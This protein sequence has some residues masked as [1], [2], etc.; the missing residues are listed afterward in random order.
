MYKSTDNCS[1]TLDHST[2]SSNPLPFFPNMGT[3]I[4]MIHCDSTLCAHL[5]G[6]KA[7]VEARN[8]AMKDRLEHL[9]AM[10]AINI[11]MQDRVAL[12]GDDNDDDPFMEDEPE[13]A[14]TVKT[15]ANSHEGT[16]SVKKE[17]EQ[18]ISDVKT[19]DGHSQSPG[20]SPRLGNGHPQ[21]ASS[22]INGS[23]PLSS[24]PPSG[25]SP[26]AFHRHW[27]DN[28]VS[29]L[30]CGGIIVVSLMLS[31]LFCIRVGESNDDG[32]QSGAA[33]DG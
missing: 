16:S 7:N 31:P 19:E 11:Q 14:K 26:G 20:Y 8:K 13:Q 32:R 1:I 5:P 25:S 21:F 15:Q 6:G 9:Y 18:E 24:S 2:L 10:H 3:C 12:Y 33:V 4:N 29:R 27:K 17:E 30:R 23:P 22:H 28:I